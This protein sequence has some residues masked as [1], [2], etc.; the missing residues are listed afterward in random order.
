MIKS[1]NFFWC[2]IILLSNHLYS[3]TIPYQA[4]LRD[5][6]GN[7]LPN[8]QATVTVRYF[9]NI[10]SNTPDYTE[11]FQES[12]NAFG[13][14]NLNLGSG[15]PIKG[16]FTDI[17]WNNGQVAFEIQVITPITT[18]QIP[19]QKFQY[20]PYAFYARET[21]EQIKSKWDY[22]LISNALVPQNTFSNANVGIGLTNP[23][24][25]LAVVS[26]NTSV[27]KAVNNGNTN[28]VSTVFEGFN[29]NGSPFS[30]VFF[31]V[32]NQGYGGYFITN[33][34]S[35]SVSAITGTAGN[36]ANG[37]IGIS[38]S[39]LGAGVVGINKNIIN[40]S[41]TSNISLGVLGV[42]NSGAKYSSGV[43]GINKNKGCGVVGVIDSLT[44]NSG[45]LAMAVKDAT[46]ANSTAL[47][48]LATGNAISYHAISTGTG[49]AILASKSGSNS[50]GPV[51]VVESTPQNTASPLISVTQNSAA[52][53]MLAF[54]AGQANVSLELANGHIKTTSIQSPT[55]SCNCG[56]QTIYS[57]V[58]GST[59]V[60]GSIYFMNTGTTTNFEL[61]LNFTKN[62]ISKPVVIVNISSPN[63]S[64][65]N[66][67]RF[68][69]IQQNSPPYNNFGVRI[70]SNLIN[71]NTSYYINYFVIE[72][73]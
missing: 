34:N 22:N 1:G 28:G 61:I 35:N 47:K 41:D 59:D 30:T 13:L 67:P 51:V 16:N 69:L 46:T 37:V 21:D 17:T 53:S 7:P 64:L 72:K 36:G 11:F 9:N 26:S 39:T 15:T 45:V 56:A 65:L 5:N 73:N 48:S 12:T 31:G 63:N 68:Y 33:A 8:I 43:L 2:I 18:I 20:V 54:A 24:S 38:Q 71:I 29:M 27:I 3:Q 23:D 62:Y 66:F 40:T 49:L 52:P 58:P 44:G 60:A 4:I 25:K 32:N 70:E 6:S 14:L 19:K 10:L 50:A 55:P 42:S 57:L